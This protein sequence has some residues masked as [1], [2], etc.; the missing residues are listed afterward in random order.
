MWAL[1]FLVQRQR[2]A[3][4]ILPSVVRGGEQSSAQVLGLLLFF[5][6]GWTVKSLKGTTE[7]STGRG[8]DVTVS[9]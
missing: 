6:L 2:E 5:C 8:S 3:R 7:E 1:L 4:V 9:E